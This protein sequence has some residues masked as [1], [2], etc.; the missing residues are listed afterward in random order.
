[1]YEHEQTF[2]H[3]CNFST[4]H[5]IGKNKRASRIYHELFYWQRILGK[6]WKRFLND[7][8]HKYNKKELK[9]YKNGSSD[10]MLMG[11]TYGLVTQS[12]CT[13]ISSSKVY[14]T[15]LKYQQTKRRENK[16]VTKYILSKVHQTNH[17]TYLGS[18]QRSPSPGCLWW[19]C[20]REKRQLF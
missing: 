8:A 1:M 15:K 7:S 19:K 13:V 6:N 10:S 3:L 2:Y 17:S 5:I 9:C 12:K 18:R 14:C 16:S 4:N 11:L 20:T